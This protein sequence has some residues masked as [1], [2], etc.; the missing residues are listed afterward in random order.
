MAVKANGTERKLNSCCLLS[1][2]GCLRSRWQVA[3]PCAPSRTVL[4]HDGDLRIVSLWFQLF[5]VGVVRSGE[6]R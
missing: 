1:S 5:E 2:P 6:M 4:R 3:D